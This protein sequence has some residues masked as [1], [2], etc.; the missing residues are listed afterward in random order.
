MGKRLIESERQG[1][2]DCS[3][4]CSGTAN[5]NQ[6]IKKVECLYRFSEVLTA[7]GK[8]VD[9]MLRATVDLIPP[10]L[11]Y[12]EIS[13]ARILFGEREF[14]SAGFR[15]TPWK[16]TADII[17][18]EKKGGAV[19]VCRLEEPRPGEDPFLKEEAH[20]IKGIARQIGIMIVRERTEEKL[21]DEAVRR[22]IL[23]EQSSDGIVV[24]DEN[25]KVYEANRRYAELLGYTPEEM[26][27]LHVWDWDTQWTREQL[28]EMIKGVSEAGDHFETRQRRKD[29]SLLDVEI[30]TNGAIC[31]GQKL[32]FCVCRDITERKRAEEQT[33]QQLGELRRW[34]EVT[35]GREERIAELKREVNELARRLGEPPR[36]ADSGLSPKRGVGP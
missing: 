19:E 1:E 15:E 24:L 23:V 7:P 26:R 16:L 28:L 4:S 18:S 35:V 22:R 20:L 30:S 27:Q 9:E 3:A 32:V 31:G 8:T 10:C 34:H 36:Y 21:A 29:G 2:D 25:G 17:V 11:P 12:P 5:L 6:R 14:A 33:K 13:C